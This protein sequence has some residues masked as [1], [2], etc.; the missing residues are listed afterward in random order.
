MDLAG[1]EY[2]DITPTPG[3]LISNFDFFFY[4]HKPAPLP[5]PRNEHLMHISIVNKCDNPRIVN[6]PISRKTTFVKFIA[7]VHQKNVNPFVKFMFSYSDNSTAISTFDEKDQPPYVMRSGQVE[8]TFEVP[9]KNNGKW[10]QHFHMFLGLIT[11]ADSIYDC[12]DLNSLRKLSGTRP[13]L[14]LIK[15]KQ[16]LSKEYFKHLRFLYK[17]GTS[18]MNDWYKAHTLGLAL[19]LPGVEQIPI[20]ASRRSK[21]KRWRIKTQL[22]KEK[23]VL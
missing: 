4:K 3:V 12:N 5:D 18:F 22:Y 10:A 23:E 6:L 14:L 15:Q 7:N 8:L 20:P 2:S 9:G 21:N 11:S 16:T 17:G 1:L 13:T 19:S